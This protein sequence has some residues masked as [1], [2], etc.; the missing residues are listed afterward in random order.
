MKKN[1][2]INLNSI[3][4]I[5]ERIIDEVTDKKISLSQKLGG[6][7]KNLRKRLIAIGS[8]A[9]SFILMFSVLLVIIIPMLGSD[10]PVYQ[11]MTIRQ[12]FS[13]YMEVPE[14]DL[15]ANGITLLSAS[16]DSGF[17]FL[18]NS[19]GNAYGHDKDNH[20]DKDDKPKNDIEDIV[21]IDVKTDDEVRYYVKPGE[22]FIIE[23]HIDNPKDYEIQS[24]TLNGQK[25]ANYMFKE[26]STM[27]LLLLEVTAPSKPGYVE[28]TIDA[29]KYID[30]TEIKDVDM[31]SGDKSVKAGIAYPTAPS[32]WVTSQSILPTSIELTV[33]VTD[34]YSLIGKNQL[35]IYL[36]DGESI[37]SSKPLTVGENNITF[38]DLTINK[39]YEYGIVTA[40]DLVDGKNLHKEWLLTN[41]ISTAGA[42]GI[43]NATSTQDSI[44]FEINKIG[45]VG[46]IT[47]ISIFDAA[48][49]DHVASGGADIREFTGLLSN[50]TYN[51]YVDFKYTLDGEEIADWVAIKGIKTKAYTKPTVSFG[52]IASTDSAV[53]GVLNMTDP[54]A[55]GTVSSVELYKDGTLVKNNAEKKINFT[56]LDSYTA[57]QIVV[58]YTFDLN[59]GVGVQTKTATYDFTTSPYLA[60]NSCNVMNTSAVSEG[61]TIFLRINI[62][63]PNKVVYQKIVVNGKEYDVVKNSSTETMLYCEI[64]N[65]GQFEGGE[66][67]LKV[68][69]VIAKLGGK[70][71]I[72][73]P[74]QNNTASVFINGKLEAESIEAVVLRDGQYVHADYVFPSEQ[75]YLILTLSNKTGHTINS[76]TL[77]NGSILVPTKIDNEHYIAELL[78]V[79]VGVQDYYLSN[80]KYTQGSTEKTLTTKNI[81]CNFF[82]LE[83]DDVQYI[84][85]PNDLANMNS[86][87]K[88][89]EL[90]NDINLSGIEWSGNEFY[91]VFNGNG[92]SISNISFVGTASVNQN[93]GLFST[94]NGVIKNLHLKSVNYLVQN[95]PEFDIALGGIIGASDSILIL[96]NCSVDEASFLSIDGNSRVGGLGGKLSG[97]VTVKNCTNYASISGNSNVGGLVGTFP[98]NG[99][100]MKN[101]TNYGNITGTGSGVGGL[102]GGED[103]GIE[104]EI[105]KTFEQCANYGNVTGYGN[106]G[107]IF[108]AHTYSGGNFIDCVNYGD[109]TAGLGGY[110]GIDS[111]AGGIASTG[112]GLT[113]KNCA[114]LGTVTAKGGAG[115][116]L[117]DGYEQQSTIDNCI[118]IGSLLG[119]NAGSLWGDDIILI[120]NCYLINNLTATQLNAKSFYTDTLGWDETVWNLDDLDVENGKYPTLK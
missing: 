67:A 111:E 86:G 113:I 24:F 69:K 43:S 59:D 107:G 112:W 15:S 68:E 66:T 5:N 63:N 9:A 78:E 90:K 30:G 34:P 119:S 79:G 47:S 50:H 12:E 2:K 73:E 16:R 84:S 53:S 10:V 118:S 55:I 41:T 102:V 71:Y 3:S 65:N 36:S 81:Y 7:T 85:T 103:G 80:V 32:A 31:S 37:I 57:Y 58:T 100:L 82:A 26:G 22:T 25:Y 117:A 17:V 105:R 38:D 83:G 108:G 91:G 20:K 72:I 44:S 51:L 101:C 13:S 23:I 88:Y 8:I 27:E 40:Y 120:T 76:F 116:I 99:S 33:N 61:G 4:N 109:I 46:E 39:T 6:T 95:N 74:K 70:T 115:G 52:S 98:S 28:Y 97:M 87:A 92:Y 89:Y 64:V 18:S 1:D 45:T 42:F 114:N 93:M 77:N 54:D 11:G 48:T 56:E 62:T 19:N 106:A 29:I 14:Y 49:N 35:A 110:Y 104:A 60:F 96:D 21:V 75:V 94:G